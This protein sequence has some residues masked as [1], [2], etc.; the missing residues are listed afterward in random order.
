MDSNQVAVSKYSAIAKAKQTVFIAVAVAA[1]VAAVAGVSIYFIMQNVIFNGKVISEQGKSIDGIKNSYN[2]IT[3]K[4][5]VEEK[6][7]SLKAKM[8]SNT[9]ML[10]LIAG[11]EGS[12]LR[13]IIDSLPSEPNPAAVQSGIEKHIFEGVD[14]KVEN[15]KVDP[16]VASTEPQA[17]PTPLTDAQKRELEN[18]PNKEDKVSQ[19]VKPINFSFTVSVKKT[20]E[21]NEKGEE[22]EKSNLDK[23]TEILQRMERSIKAFRVNSYK[24]E[25]GKES[26]TLSVSGQTYYL[27]AYDLKLNK[28]TIK[29][30]DGKPAKNNQNSTTGVK[31]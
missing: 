30:D 3:K 25:Y 18:D 21:K 9:D 31:N 26:S 4:D 23:L 11:K 5:G 22:V 13:L 12:V 1:F 14:V 16:V 15:I 19:R 17:E 20:K 6:A 28:K 29:S 2:N 24:M 8:E 27:P 7:R 10:N